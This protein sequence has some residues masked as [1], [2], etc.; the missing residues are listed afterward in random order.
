M[1]CNEQQKA[2]P[3]YNPAHQ[4]D[5]T[6]K[7]HSHNNQCPKQSRGEM[8]P[9]TRRSGQGGAAEICLIFRL[10]LKVAALA[11]AQTGYC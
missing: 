10:L 2:N 6:I 8:L 7:Y 4:L 5:D 1:R 3:K 9:G 11:T